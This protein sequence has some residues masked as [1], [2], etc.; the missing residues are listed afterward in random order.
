MKGKPK[1]SQFSTIRS[2]TQ[3]KTYNY[4]YHAQHAIRNVAWMKDEH[5]HKRKVSK[6]LHK[7]QW[8]GTTKSLLINDIPTSATNGYNN[9]IEK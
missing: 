9:S 7:N 5:N 6:K 4:K 8:E 1:F 3:T 2:R